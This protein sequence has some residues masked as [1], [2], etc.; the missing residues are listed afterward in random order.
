MMND[1]LINGW[2][3]PFILVIGAISI[4]NNKSSAIFL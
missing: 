3:Y 2:L 4:Q 1:N